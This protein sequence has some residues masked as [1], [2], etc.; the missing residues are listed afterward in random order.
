MIST[1]NEAD[2]IH[3]WHLF[4]YIIR[5]YIIGKSRNYIIGAY[6]VT[7]SVDFVTLSVD[8]TL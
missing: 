8:I 3:Y 6:F 1:S 7:L 4:C 5:R 2:M